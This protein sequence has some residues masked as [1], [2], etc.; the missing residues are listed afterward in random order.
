MRV[1]VGFGGQCTARIFLLVDRNVAR[2]P[3][4][5]LASIVIA[6]GRTTPSQYKNKQT[7]TIKE[8]ILKSLY[9]INDLKIYGHLQPN[10]KK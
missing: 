1:S 9:D 10:F 4:R 3:A 6:N 2:N 7:M 8:G 5:V